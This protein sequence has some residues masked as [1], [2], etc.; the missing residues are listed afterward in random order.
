MENRCSEHKLVGCHS[1]YL[2]SHS[3]ISQ[4]DPNIHWCNCR[5]IIRVSSW[6]GMLWDLL[7]LSEVPLQ[8]PVS[9]I[10]LKQFP[11]QMC[12]NNPQHLNLYA[13]C[14][15]ANNSKNK[16]SPSM[17]FVIKENSPMCCKQADQQALDL[18]HA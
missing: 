7:Q 4:S 13:W 1:I 2:P 5:I 10:L 17:C 11:N 6:P 12:L 16:T 8:L 3:S 15:G 18:V 14:L 9:R